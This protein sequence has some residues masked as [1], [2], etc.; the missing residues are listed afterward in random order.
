M[1]ERDDE[2]RTGSVPT[3][4]LGTKGFGRSRSRPGGI[5]RRHRGGVCVRDNQPLRRQSQ[6]K[7]REQNL[8]SERSR[9]Q[10]DGMGVYDNYKTAAMWWWWWWWRR[11]LDSFLGPRHIRT[12]VVVVRHP[13]Q[14][15][16]SRQ[17][18]LS[19]TQRT[20]TRPNRC[21]RGGSLPIRPTSRPSCSP[22]FRVC[23][24][25]FTSWPPVCSADLAFWASTPDLLL[26]CLGALNLGSY[27][28]DDASPPPKPKGGGRASC[29][30]GG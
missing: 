15:V 28:V 5:C 19:D 12:I 1:R 9:D 6:D 23:Q 21:W 14:F 22:E 8:D 26:E 20:G 18:A 11:R 27:L 29:E 25:T 7:E 24:K 2:A 17:V 16:C 30:S 4:L 13:S 3:K 10:A